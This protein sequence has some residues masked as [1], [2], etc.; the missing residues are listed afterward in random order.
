MHRRLVTRWRD[1]LANDIFDVIR[2]SEGKL[3]VLGHPSL[4]EHMGVERVHEDT[5]EVFAI[6]PSS[7]GKPT[8]LP[9]L[10]GNL[11]LTK[12]QIFRV[13]SVARNSRHYKLLRA[14]PGW[15]TTTGRLARDTLAR[16]ADACCVID[17]FSHASD[18]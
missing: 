7:A 14:R 10:L 17:H 5:Q 9:T 8:L 1:A 6:W 15:H 18:P 12:H 16:V 3:D 4:H 2:K 13:V 11:D